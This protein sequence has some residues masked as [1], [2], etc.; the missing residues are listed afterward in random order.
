MVNELLKIDFNILGVIVPRI[1]LSKYN[2]TI[3]DNI[4]KNIEETKKVCL[5]EGEELLS[6]KNVS[7]LELATKISEDVIILHDFSKG[8]NQKEMR[9]FHNMFKRMVDEY[10]KKIILI[11][12][13]VNFLARFCDA[14]AVYDKKAVY[15]TNDIFD[16]KLYSYIDMPKAVSFIKN[17]NKKGAGLANNIDL[18]ELIKDVYRRKNAN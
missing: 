5:L 15:E 16:D 13:D 10:H 2:G 12:R 11:S 3:D 7:K 8:L 6:T 17:A 9:Y 4:K 18:N 1:E 14:F